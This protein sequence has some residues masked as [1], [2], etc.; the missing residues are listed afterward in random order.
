MASSFIV[1]LFSSSSWFSFCNIVLATGCRVGKIDI[2]VWAIL[3]NPVAVFA[4]LFHG[5]LALS[6]FLTWRRTA[7]WLMLF[8]QQG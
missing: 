1:Y 2:I 4:R 5:K 3:L 6:G 8:P 7:I